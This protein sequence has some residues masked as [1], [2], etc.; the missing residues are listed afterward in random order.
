MLL[1]PLNWE[2]T[3]PDKYL[4]INCSYKP[5]G[6][7]Y[8]LIE[9]IQQRY[10]NSEVVDLPEFKA[11]RD[12]EVKH[13]R[14]GIDHCFREDSGSLFDF[15]LKLRNCKN[16]IFA[17]P[18]YLN[19]PTPKLLSFLSRLATYNDIAGRNLFKDHYAYIAVNAD[20]SG[21]Q[22]TASVLMNALN[23][24]GFDFR[25]KCILEHI[26]EWKTNKVRGGYLSEVVPLIKS[27]E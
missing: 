10:V 15:Y 9:A 8:K 22:Q 11:C 23:M 18:V 12:C 24:L 26:N 17:T 20:V 21:S 16:I 14:K 5:R 1:G 2:E 25:G 7:T 4:I 13:C 3:F 6:N 19:L 27:K